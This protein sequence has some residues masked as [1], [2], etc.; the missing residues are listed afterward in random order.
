[1]LLG[2]WIHPFWLIIAVWWI[3]GST[4]RA[5]TITLKQFTIEMGQIAQIDLKLKSKLLFIP[6]W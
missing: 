4:V 3:R 6:H 5:E 1:M 2:P